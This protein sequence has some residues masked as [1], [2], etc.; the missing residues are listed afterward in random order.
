MDDTRESKLAQETHNADAK[1]QKEDERLLNI[2][3]DQDYD[4]WSYEQVARYILDHFVR[5]TFP[6]DLDLE[7]QV[8][9]S[10]KEQKV[11][12]KVLK[13][14]SSMKKEKA[15]AT[16]DGKAN[17]WKTLVWAINDFVFLHLPPAEYKRGDLHPL[18]EAIYDIPFR[19]GELDN[20][21]WSIALQYY[22]RAPTFDQSYDDGKLWCHDRGGRPY[23]APIGW[24]R[25][26]FVPLKDGETVNELSEKI[27]DWH[28]GY[29]GTSLINVSSIIE[30]GLVPPGT[31]LPNNEVVKSKHG[32]V[33]A[34][35]DSIPIYISPSVEYAAHPLY[36]KPKPF[37]NKYIYA[38]F[39]VRVNPQS[40][41]TVQ[42]NTL[43][44]KLWGDISIIYDQL[45]SPRE[46]EW[47]LFDPEHIRVTGLMI[48][49]DSQDPMECIKKRFQDNKKF[50]E[51]RRNLT[52]IP[53]TWY[54]N[55]DT[56]YTF[57]KTGHYKPYTP[58]Q[59][60]IIEEAYRNG[61]IAVWLGKVK[62]D[63]GSENVYFIDF[64]DEKQINCSNHKLKRRVKRVPAQQ[65]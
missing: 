2:K 49:V 26:G 6:P 56:D 32:K 3:E 13:E 61:Q 21:L 23:F 65:Q 45:Y 33:G 57:S 1:L 17:I 52:K 8:L 40:N 60:K 59:N 58:E 43:A 44:D 27:K 54:W 38:V 20:G 9:F 41:Y 4:K 30:A 48:K 46:L 16:V 25:Y 7:K 12:G 22:I 37:G 36:T 15:S 51:E 31:V 11:D 47:L 34:K 19:L 29:H 14:I 55:C 62:T 24:R 18:M 5:I 53:G 35:G 64:I 63:S 39:Q 28:V 42:S 10:V 50:L